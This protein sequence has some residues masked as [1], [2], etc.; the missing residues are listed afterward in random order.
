MKIL[1]CPFCRNS[2]RIGCDDIAMDFFAVFC[3]QCGAMGPTHQKREDGTWTENES[4]AEATAAW[5]SRAIREA[6]GDA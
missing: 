5:N 2:E 6:I 4:V 3:P 1:P